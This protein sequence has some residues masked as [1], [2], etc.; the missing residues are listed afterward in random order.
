VNAYSVSLGASISPPWCDVERAALETG[1]V[2]DERRRSVRWQRE[3]DR[4]REWQDVASEPHASV[5]TDHGGR[6]GVSFSQTSS[7]CFLCSSIGARTRA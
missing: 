2:R 1:V 5:E 7:S 4:E 3:H 6:Y